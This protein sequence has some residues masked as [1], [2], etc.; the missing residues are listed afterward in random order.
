VNRLLGAG[1]AAAILVMPGLAACS[2]GHAAAGP[3]A[4]TSSRP[5]ASTGSRPAAQETPGVSV[6]ALGAI[7]GTCFTGVYDTT[8]NEFNSL[9][10]LAQ[11][12]DISPGDTIAEAYQVQLANP[13]RSV[14]Q[15]VTGFTVEFYA[16]RRQLGSNSQRLAVPADI[17]PGASMVWTEQPWGTSV[18]DH[19]P[20]IG[21]FATGNGG[22]LDPAATCNLVSWS[23]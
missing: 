11:G 6:R 23:G 3:A 1:A 22:A 9:A 2:G 10:G 7:D 13:S 15:K 20:S 4:R 21:P 19:G 18:A 12:S 8:Q 5:A 17:A 14:A 16:A